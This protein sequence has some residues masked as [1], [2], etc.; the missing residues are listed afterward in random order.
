MIQ[1]MIKAGLL[2]LLFS[3]VQTHAQN[4]RPDQDL[5]VND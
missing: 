1:N 3:S 4:Y 5:Y 2:V